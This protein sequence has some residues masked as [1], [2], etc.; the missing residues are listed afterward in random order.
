MTR[1]HGNEET[2][3]RLERALKAEIGRSGAIDAKALERITD[4]WAVRHPTAASRFRRLLEEA[5]RESGLGSNPKTPAALE[6]VD[7]QATTLDR[8]PRSVKP[9]TDTVATGHGS[10]RPASFLTLSISGQIDLPDG[11]PATLG[12]YQ[13]HRVLGKG[14]MGIVYLALDTRL[15]RPVAIK[16]LPPALAAEGEMLRRF[17]RETAAVATLEH[18]SIVPVYE[19]GRDQG[20]NFYVMRF[21]DGDSLL[22][23][24]RRLMSAAGRTGSRPAPDSAAVEE[25]LRDP[26][27]LESAEPLPAS[28]IAA[29]LQIV[30]Q[31]ALALEHAHQ[32]GIIHRD[33]KPANIMVDREGTAQLLDFGL[34]KFAGLETLTRTGDVVGTTSYMSPEQLSPQTRAV[35]HHTDIYSLGVTLYECVTGRKPFVGPSPEAIVF[36]ILTNEPIPPRRHRPELAKE[37]ETV[38]LKCLEKNP[39]RRYASGRDLA[40]DIAHIRAHRRIDAVPVGRFGRIQR[41]GECHRLQFAILVFLGL[42]LIGFPI[43]VAARGWERARERTRTAMNELRQ[44]RSYRD[45]RGALVR[46]QQEL[47]IE[48]RAA[49]HRATP[50]LPLSDPRKRDYYELK[51]ETRRVR[52]ELD[53]LALK[54]R[55]AFDRVL[56]SDSSMRDVVHAERQEFLFDLYRQAER[57]R[58]LSG[59]EVYRHELA[60]GPYADQRQGRGHLSLATFPDGAEVAIHRWRDRGNG[61]LEIDDGKPVRRRTPVVALELPSGSYVAAL[62]LPG[63]TTTHYPFVIE[64]DEHWGHPSWHQGA[65]KDETWTVSLPKLEHVDAQHWAFVPAGPYQST[66]DRESTAREPELVWRWED[67]FIIGKHE[68]TYADYDA[69]F[70]LDETQAEILDALKSRARVLYVPRAFAVA[71]LLR[72]VETIVVDRQEKLLRWKL[73]PESM[74]RALSGI[75]WTD[76]VGFAQWLTSTTGYGHGLPSPEQ[77][78]KAARGVDGRPYPWGRVFDWSFV[79]SYEIAKPEQTLPRA[80]GSAPDDRSPYGIY[81]LAG[82]AKEWCRTGPEI[83]EEASTPWLLGGDLSVN[84][85]SGMSF[86]CWPS[87][88][89]PF[90]NVGM[91]WGL[92]LVRGLTKEN[93]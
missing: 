67:S 30:E 40:N 1:R 73:T 76:A 15:H 18:P 7:D 33:I 47:E 14:G 28:S 71:P 78:E 2:L 55:F 21:V 48:L 37:I 34:A 69:F 39:A 62:S 5:L 66:A 54:A 19:V 23:H 16:V 41:W 57:S 32:Q 6:D 65:F 52:R 79:S 90:D 74:P 51:E 24:A 60:A 26:A 91:G 20:F 46:R 38:I 89:V 4:S 93:R 11:S 83:H 72:T 58:D 92:R 87:R 22:G 56:E 84:A 10:R 27:G 17:E 35:D 8:N 42:V 82:N 64:R 36:Q 45:E 61:R 88:F 12:H 29:I 68:V 80:P 59:V 85:A 50:H 9:D 3:E 13:L 43:V 31:T 44:A 70:A 25:S 75:S 63:H 81:D 77:W 86:T 53:A 49:K